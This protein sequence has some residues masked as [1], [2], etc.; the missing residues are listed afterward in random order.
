[1]YN[2]VLA[3]INEHVNSEVAGRYAKQLAK[4]T[5]ARLYL[6]SI[7]A[8]EQTEKSIDLARAAANRLLHAARELDVDAEVLFDTG[9]PVAKI[10]QIVRSHD[11]DLVFAAT[12]HEDVQKRFYAGPTTARKL[13]RQLA[14]SVALMRVV[15]MGR[16]YPR[17]ILIPLKEQIDHIPERAYFAAMLARAFDARVNLFHVTKPVYK[18]FNGAVDLRPVEWEVKIP[19]DISRFIN[20]LDRYGVVHENRSALGAEGKSITIEAASKRRDL[21]VMGASVR[22]FIDFLLRG[23]PVEYVLRET[24]CNL[25]ILKPGQ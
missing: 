15:Q 5:G 22:G 4:Q 24:P 3:A 18:F 6:C 20:H 17:E 7:A 9:D 25:I 8:P 10:R 21:I 2:K 12:R 14:C 16:I 23:N 1:M 13:L 19:P 11:I